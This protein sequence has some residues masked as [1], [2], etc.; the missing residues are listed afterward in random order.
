MFYHPCP[1]APRKKC[2]DLPTPLVSNL[3]RDILQ[4]MITRKDIGRKAALNWVPD[5]VFTIVGVDEVMGWAR[6][7]RPDVGGAFTVLTKNLILF[8]EDSN[9]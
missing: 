6:V 3:E 1:K 5:V 9:V 2:N 7:T 8:P 4:Y